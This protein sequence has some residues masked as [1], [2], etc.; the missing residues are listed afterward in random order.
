MLVNKLKFY[1]RNFGNW[2]RDS[3]KIIPPRLIFLFNEVNSFE[4]SEANLQHNYQC[5]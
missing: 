3:L 1:M 4:L 2:E 5:S